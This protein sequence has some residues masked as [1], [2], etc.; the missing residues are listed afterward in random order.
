MCF[1]HI[2][3]R[4]REKRKKVEWKHELP[5]VL[6]DDKCPGQEATMA[7]MRGNG[8]RQDAFAR[9]TSVNIRDSISIWRRGSSIECNGLPRGSPVRYRTFHSLRVRAGLP[10]RFK[11]NVCPSDT[12]SQSIETGR[13]YRLN[14]FSFMLFI[15]LLSLSLSRMGKFVNFVL[16]ESRVSLVTSECQK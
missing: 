4:E 12:E 5:R 1:H 15:I 10:D 6:A 7:I 3:S 13:E 11:P 16:R 9:Q 8:T 14:G 2:E